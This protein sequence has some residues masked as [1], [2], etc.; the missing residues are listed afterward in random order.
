[1]GVEVTGQV[2]GGS[3]VAAGETITVSVTVSSTKD[4]SSNNSDDINLVTHR[5]GDVVAWCSAQIHCIC[6]SN[7]AYVIAPSPAKATVAAG[8]LGNLTSAG[9]SLA[10]WRGEG[11]HLVLTTKPTIL[12]CDL[13]LPPGHSRTCGCFVCGRYREVVPVTGPPSYRGVH[14]KYS[15][16]VT[17]GAQR[18]GRKVVLLRLPLRVLLLP[19]PP[20][21]ALEDAY[22]ESDDELSPSNPFLHPSPHAC[23]S[24]APNAALLQAWTAPSARAYNVVHSRGHVV[25]FRLFRSRYRL[26][27]DLLATLDFSAAQIPC[28]Q[29]AVCLQSVEE[30]AQEHRKR[31]QQSASVVSHS[32]T[33]EVCLSMT[34]TS[35]LMPVPLHITP[36]FDAHM[37]QLMP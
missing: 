19:P 4:C 37:G 36:S 18:H 11:G 30:V 32:K 23:S 2:E 21:G 12:F 13:H 31:R 8:E 5:S 29:Y 3:V 33:H 22:S 14:V 24:P 7:D 26:G 15:W 10:P 16:K 25:Q 17:V 6:T 1:M 9:T 20:P 34:H 35:L 28:V 27:D